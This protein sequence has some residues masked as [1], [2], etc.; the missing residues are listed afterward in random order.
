MSP[1]MRQMVDFLVLPWSK[2]RK[3]DLK[4]LRRNLGLCSRLQKHFL[5]ILLLVVKSVRNLWRKARLQL[6]SVFWY[7]YLKEEN[8][9]NQLRRKTGSVEGLKQCRYSDKFCF[10]LIY[11]I[12]DNN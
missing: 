9:E 8:E 1:L 3:K 10:D 7:S 6:F 4:G 5:L 2:L 12:K 11:A